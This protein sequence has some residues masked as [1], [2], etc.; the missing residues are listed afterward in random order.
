MNNENNV[1]TPVNNNNQGSVLTPVNGS[2]PTPAPIEQSVPTP[3]PAPVEVSAPTPAPAPVEPSVPTQAPVPVEPST[4]TPAPAPVEPSVPTPSTGEA[5]SGTTPPPEKKS[6]VGL[7]I[8]IVVLL[9]ALGVGAYFLFGK[10]DDTPTNNQNNNQE[11][12]QNNN[13]NN[14]NNNND[15]TFKASSFSGVYKLD[16]VTVV[17]FGKDSNNKLYYDISSGTNSSS[18]DASVLG[19]SAEA[20]IFDTTFKFTINNGNLELT[21]NDEKF[22]SGTYNKISD[23]KINDFYNDHYGKEEF[24]DTKYNGDYSN[25]TT[26]VYV[27][28]ESESEVRIYFMGTAGLHDISYEIKDDGSLYSKFF[29]DEYT[30]TFEGDKMTYTSKKGDG[31]KNEFDGTYTKVKSLSLEEIVDYVEGH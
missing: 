29:D 9:V 11:N 3:A 4:P 5:N 31:S 16:D 6:K 1:L 18:G 19:T 23:Y 13:Q 12:G 20:E 26:K 17:L 14:N 30:V 2:V 8:I 27:Y 10:K 24:I 21:T 25:D 15:A 22:K 28:Q 7:I